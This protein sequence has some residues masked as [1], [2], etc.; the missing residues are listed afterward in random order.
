MTREKPKGLVCLVTSLLPNLVARTPSKPQDLE[1]FY[2]KSTSQSTPPSHQ[3]QKPLLTPPRA[4]L[5]HLSRPRPPSVLGPALK[6]GRK[7]TH[8]RSGI[9]R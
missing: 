6:R 9:P 3:E 4:L 7:E 8:T 1:Q 2:S 5:K